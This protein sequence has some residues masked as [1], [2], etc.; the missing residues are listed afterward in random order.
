MTPLLLSEKAQ[1]V[2]S[3]LGALLPFTAAA[4]RGVIP[5]KCEVLAK[6]CPVLILHFFGDLLP[7][8]PMRRGIVELAVQT[9][10]EISSTGL[11][12][13]VACNGSRVFN[14]CA[15]G[16]AYGHGGMIPIRIIHLKQDSEPALAKR[17]APR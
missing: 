10:P 4:I 11:T 13:R 14:S 17:A 3:R 2:V 12:E 16:V 15:A 8:L 5:R 6:V 9:H 7:T 1:E